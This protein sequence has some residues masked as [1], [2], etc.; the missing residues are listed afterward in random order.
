MAT[1]KPIAKPSQA[2]P[3]PK[4]ASSSAPQP[5]TKQDQPVFTDFASI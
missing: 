5:G 1:S 4:A 3:A 2:T